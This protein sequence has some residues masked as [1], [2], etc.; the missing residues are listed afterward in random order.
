F[1]ASPIRTP[2]R[3]GVDRAKSWAC[4]D[5]QTTV[6][7][8]ERPMVEAT[9]SARN[10]VKSPLFMEDA[11]LWRAERHSTYPKYVTSTRSLRLRE[12][13]LDPA[14]RGSRLPPGVVPE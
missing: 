4:R 7:S 14:H 13:N 1:L 3:S 11:W 8:T 12:L 6:R 10:T 2:A 5:A 9:K